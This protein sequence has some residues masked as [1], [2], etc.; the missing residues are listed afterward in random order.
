M[1][2]PTLSSGVSV[3]PLGL[4]TGDL[5]GTAWASN[6]GWA[7]SSQARNSDLHR[8]AHP[9]ESPP[10]PALP[11]K[12]LA[13]L[14]GGG[15]PAAGPAPSGQSIRALFAP[16]WSPEEPQRAGS[17]LGQGRLWARGRVR[18]GGRHEGTR[19]GRAQAPAG[20]R[21][22]FRLLL[23]L[24]SREQEMGS[25]SSCQ[26]GQG[27]PSS[28]W[29]GWTLGPGPPLFE[30]RG[31]SFHHPPLSYTHS[32]GTNLR[33]SLSIQYSVRESLFSTECLRPDRG[34]G[35]PALWVNH[36]V[37]AQLSPTW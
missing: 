1:T 7:Q 30:C 21:A 18:K 36:S 37:P 12:S 24:C 3:F 2:N 26:F 22:Q 20:R 15:G 4:E 34:R 23:A 32:S 27:L 25:R 35:L 9:S 17:R 29:S 6:R 14:R 28:S 10:T 16:T 31:I 5:E 11:G 13:G 8:P 19:G 33:V